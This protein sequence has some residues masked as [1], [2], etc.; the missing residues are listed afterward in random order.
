MLCSCTG[1]MHLIAIVFRVRV[2]FTCLSLACICTSTRFRRRFEIQRLAEDAKEVGSRSWSCCRL[3]VVACHGFVC[4]CSSCY[5]ASRAHPY[6]HGEVVGRQTTLMS[7]G[8][9]CSLE[10]EPFCTLRT[11]VHTVV[12]IYRPPDMKSTRWPS[13][14]C[15]VLIS[16]WMGRKTAISFI[17]SCLMVTLARSHVQPR[18][19]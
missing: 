15:R 14:A 2:G 7:F 6:A 16:G 5:L 19:M 8:C 18:A 1:C 10:D 17:R 4:M 13:S 12:L 3:K 9:S 11:G